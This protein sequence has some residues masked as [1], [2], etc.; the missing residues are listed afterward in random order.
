M[1]N[2]VRLPPR[3]YISEL[4]QRAPR[5]AASAQY[6]SL[7]S[8]DRA[9]AGLVFSAFARFVEASLTDETVRDECARA[10]EEF[11]ASDDHEAHNLLVV[12]VFEA[13][14][15]PEVS[16]RRLL[17]ASRALYERWLRP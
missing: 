3:D 15:T 1:G 10:I 16:T 13:F 8:D 9:V 17:P 5:F 6:R 7:S 4:L 2:F 11:A 14:R 12:E